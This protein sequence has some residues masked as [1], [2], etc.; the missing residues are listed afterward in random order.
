MPASCARGPALHT[1][2]P[3]APSALLGR[4]AGGG[5]ISSAEECKQSV[6]GHAAR[7]SRTRGSSPGSSS[8]PM[9]SPV[10]KMEGTTG[11]ERGWVSSSKSL[12]PKILQK[13]SASHL[14]HLHVLKGQPGDRKPPNGHMSEDSL[15]FFQD[16][17]GV[18][19][20]HSFE[21]TAELAAS[22]HRQ[23]VSASPLQLTLPLLPYPHLRL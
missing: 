4:K 14:P 18:I 11:R 12:S 15:A 6:P 13:S 3:F 23:C 1:R 17:K 8:C 5:P 7:K 21:H 19:L 10:C 9:W 2:T 16:R 22:L 20:A